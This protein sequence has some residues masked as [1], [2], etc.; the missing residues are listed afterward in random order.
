MI[1]R[2]Y[3]IKIWDGKRGLG[4]KHNSYIAQTIQHPII[5]VRRNSISHLKND[6]RA[7]IDKIK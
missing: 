5:T 6:M 7:E 2:G 3:E 4:S 1:Y